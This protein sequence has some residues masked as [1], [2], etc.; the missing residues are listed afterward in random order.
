MAHIRVQT[1]AVL[2]HL[3]CVGVERKKEQSK[4]PL[5]CGGIGIN[6]ILLLF[7]K[8]KAKLQKFYA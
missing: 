1:A 2:T 5:L 4:E 8:Q 6:Q 3:R 7:E